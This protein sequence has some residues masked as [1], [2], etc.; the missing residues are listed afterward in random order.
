MG[1]AEKN[2]EPIGCTV[3][4]YPSHGVYGRLVTDYGNLTQFGSGSQENSRKIPGGSI[5]AGSEPAVP[6]CQKL[7]PSLA[8]FARRSMGSGT[9]IIDKMFAS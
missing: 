3:F 8:V 7:E 1:A 5:G 4:G 6:E 9:N 2:H